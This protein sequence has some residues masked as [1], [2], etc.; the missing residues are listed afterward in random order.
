MHEIQN[1]RPRRNKSADHCHDKHSDNPDEPLAQFGQMFD[2][3]CGLLLHSLTNLIFL[4]NRVKLSIDC[5]LTI[6]LVHGVN[7]TDRRYF[8]FFRSTANL[9]E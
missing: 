9:A 4:N 1:E 8:G 7:G 2:Q 3:G 5:A 6:G